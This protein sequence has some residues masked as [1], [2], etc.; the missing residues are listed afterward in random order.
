MTEQPSLAPCPFHRPPEM[1]KA[2]ASRPF[3]I[4]TGMYQAAVWCP[5]CG[6]L[7][8]QASSHEPGEV[9]TLAEAV[10]AWN[11]RTLT[12]TNPDARAEAVIAAAAT[13]N[14]PVVLTGAQA[15][16]MAAA[17]LRP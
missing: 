10:E 9:A 14:M 4:F 2:E 6:A 5:V 13:L 16:A 7:G 17:Y 8:P 15:K 11:A 3:P 1:E 12:P